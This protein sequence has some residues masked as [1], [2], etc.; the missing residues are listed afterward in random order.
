VLLR[1][2]SEAL[3]RAG[4]PP[5]RVQAEVVDLTAVLRDPPPPQES[6]EDWQE[7]VDTLP[8]GHVLDLHAGLP[9]VPLAMGMGM[10]PGAADPGNWLA[11]LDAGA[12][13]RLFLQGRWMTAQLRWVSP[14]RNLFLFNSRHGGRAHSLTRRMLQKLRN[15]G[16]ATSIE[17]GFLLAQAM[18]TLAQSTLG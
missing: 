12:Y 10:D 5:A 2:V 18:D 13:C 3:D 7:A 15:A 14:T 6:A 16:L 4:L 11:T 8:A 9:T 1:Q 17:D